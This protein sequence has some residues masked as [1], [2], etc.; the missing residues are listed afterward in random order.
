[1]TTCA[2]CAEAIDPDAVRCP[3][4]DYA[5]AEEYKEKSS[6]HFAVAGMAAFFFW[7][8]VALP[9]VPIYLWSGWKYRKKAKTATPAD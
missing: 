7:T 4:C 1:M 8:I 2:K 6:S 5:P 9:F 3:H